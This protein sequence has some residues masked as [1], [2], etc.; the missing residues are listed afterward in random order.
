M[1]FKSIA[2]GLPAG[3]GAAAGQI[4]FDANTAE[5]TRTPESISITEENTSVANV[6]E[7]KPSIHVYSANMKYPVLPTP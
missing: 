1:K 7:M 2:N 5:K 6:R 4:V 3:P